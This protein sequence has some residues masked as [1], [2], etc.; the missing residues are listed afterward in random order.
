MKA[1]VYDEFGTPD[2]LN[3]RDVPEPEPRPGSVRVRVAAAALNP[4]DVLVRKGKMKWLTGRRFPRIPGYDF[5]GVLLD[6]GGGFEAGEEVF[7]MVNSHQGGTCAEVVSVPTDELAARP[8]SLS[9]AEAASLPL[10]SLTALQALRDDLGVAEGERVLMN[11]ASGGVGT[12]AVQIG[13]ILGLEVIGVSSSRNVEMVCEL[14][15]TRVIDY[16]KEE[17]LDERGLDHFFDI[18]GNKPW[19]HA[20]QTL[21]KGGRYC[22]TVPTPG[23][24]LRG[25]LAR[26]GLHRASM[27]VVESRRQDLELVARWVEEGQLVP[28]VDRVYTMEESVEANEYIETRRARG[29]V[30]IEIDS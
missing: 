28:V 12:A 19:S 24:I 15:A 9:M 22:T 23:S 30:V 7:G 3:V 14:G 26:V 16:T 21:A 8:A 18:Y 29:K 13:R 6:D 5:A 17:P 4:K 2:V 10:V 27:V 1:I 11:G 20:K 25:G